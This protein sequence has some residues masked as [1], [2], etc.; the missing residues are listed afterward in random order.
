[1]FYYNRNFTHLWSWPKHFT[2]DRLRDCDTEGISNR[3]D[4]NST[5]NLVHVHGRGVRAPI[6]VAA[7]TYFR[8]PALHV[9]FGVPRQEIPVGEA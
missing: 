1:M 2:E 4:D 7:D 6:Q 5:E 9:A 8:I 3:S